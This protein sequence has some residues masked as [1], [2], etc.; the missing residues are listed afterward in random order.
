[1][2]FRGKPLGQISESDLQGLVAA[3]VQE[4]HQIEYKRI[5]KVGNPEDNRETLLD[6]AAFAN[7]S[8]G[9]ILYGVEEDKGVPTKLAGLE[10]FNADTEA[11]RIDG[12]LASWTDKK[13][14]GVGYQLVHLASG[15]GVFIVRVPNLSSTLHAVTLGGNP[16]YVTRNASGRANMTT[17]GI[18]VAI[19]YTGKSRERAKQ[20][21]SQR[22]VAIADNTLP[23][24][25]AAPYRQVLYVLPLAELS[26]FNAREVITTLRDDFHPMGAPR[27]MDVGAT[28]G[29]VMAFSSETD[30]S[31]YSY[32]QIHRNGA[33]EAVICRSGGTS[34]DKISSDYERE[35]R[36]SL[37]PYLRALNRLSLMPPYLVGVSHLNVVGFSIYEPPHV[38][39]FRPQLAQ[40][41]QILATGLYELESIDTASV[42]A[43]LK[44]LFDH[45]W[46]EFGRLGSPHFT[47]DGKWEPK[48]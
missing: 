3:Q 39:Y 8:G 6:I 11:Q 1:M 27:S 26:N 34:G 33:L 24:T 21:R 13:I 47:P 29:G 17:A 23:I 5:W 44:S 22:D 35:M 14:V 12:L 9:D 2:N 18:E 28:Q 20:F 40:T 46:N 38:S 4:G 45:V 41:G 30:R 31:I 32:V 36:N 10:N 42:D 43:A 37:L 15:Q 25:L 19:L 7:A 16:R 48:Q